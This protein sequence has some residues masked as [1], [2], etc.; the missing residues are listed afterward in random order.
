MPSGKVHAGITLATA[1]VTYT[2]GMKSGDSPDYAVAT[3]LG[4]LSGILLTPDLDV[5]G[6]RA[7]KI[8]RENAG[9]IPAVVW[10]LFWNP[11]SALIPHRSV[12]SHGLIIGTLIRLVYIAVPL[13]LF[14][15]LPGPGPVIDRLIL[16]LVLSDN[17]HIGA[18]FLVSG[19]KDIVDKKRKD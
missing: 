15:I 19:L 6:T 11:Y 2:I 16:G 18:D 5:K 9:L 7:D 14:G 12:L 8:V 10:G 3:A 17:M 1:L 4:C 13:A